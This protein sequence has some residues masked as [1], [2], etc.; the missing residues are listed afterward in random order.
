MKLEVKMMVLTSMFTALIAVGAFIKI[1]LGP[2]LPA[3]TLQV[4]FVV[5]S[6]LILGKY[7]GALCQI[8]YLTLGLI[9]IPVFTNGSGIAYVMQPSFGYILGFIPAAFLIG[10]LSEKFEKKSFFILLLCCGVGM[11]ID[12]IV[13]VPY[14]YAVLKLLLH[15]DIDV[16]GVVKKGFIIFV[17]GDLIKCVLASMLAVR[18]MPRL[19]KFES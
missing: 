2:F 18:I 7:Y 11:L 14:L 12:Y 17:P 8:L 6:A 4:F 15:Q 5:L 13:G 1:P 19:R 10:Y 16:M 3:I 9:G